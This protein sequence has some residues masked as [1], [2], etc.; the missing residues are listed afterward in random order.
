MRIL[1]KENVTVFHGVPIMYDVLNRYM[2]KKSFVLPHLR[3]CISA[4]APLACDIYKEFCKNT[5]VYISH[6]LGSTE[7]GT[8]AINLN[9]SHDSVYGLVGSPLKGVRIK[10]N[11][12]DGELWVNSLGR[13]VGY[14]HDNKIFDEWQKTGDIVNLSDGKLQIIG[15]KSMFINVAGKK[16][17]PYEV[18]AVIKKIKGIQDVVVFAESDPITNEHVCAN[19]VKEETISEEKIRQYCASQLSAYKIPKRIRFVNSLKKTD[20]GK[21]KKFQE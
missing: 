9:S 7:T 15:R 11:P 14:F 21:N 4:G 19:I 12:I 20:L 17:N 6:E 2:H 18:E 8:I 10:V 3:L 13:P 1:Q 16:V 5:G